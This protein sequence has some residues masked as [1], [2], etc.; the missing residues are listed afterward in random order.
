MSSLLGSILSYRAPSPIYSVFLNERHFM[1]QFRA[2]ETC[3][4][5]K[6]TSAETFLKVYYERNKED[7]DLLCELYQHNLL[8]DF[9]PK[10]NPTP[11]VGDIQL[12]EFTSFVRN[13]AQWKN[14]LFVS[15]QNENCSLWIR[16]EFPEPKTVLIS[17]Y[18]WV[19]S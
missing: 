7:K 12:R 2:V 14:A 6:V 1:F 16:R 5:Y 3:K 13:H 19:N 15:Q 10:W 18:A 17:H 8:L 4:P 9:D 11:F